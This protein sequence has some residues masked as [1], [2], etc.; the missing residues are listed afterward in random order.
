MQKQLIGLF[1]GFLIIMAG[2]APGV[3]AENSPC[4]EKDAVC[5][6][7]ARL[8]EAEQF[9]KI[10]EKID[11]KKTYSDASRN[12]IGQAY[13]MIAGRETSTPE[14][15][16]QFCRKALEYGS[17]SAY[18]GLY[19]IYAAKDPEAALGFLKQYIA[20]KPRDS[21][22]Y[23]IMGEAELE[24]KNYKAADA[25]LREAK[26]VARGHS[27][28]LE[29][30]S[31]QAGYLTGDYVYAG[32]MLDSAL[33]KPEYGKELRALASDPRFS[34]M[35]KRPEFKQYESLFKSAVR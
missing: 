18:M 32:T 12:I 16:E 33:K 13:L 9:D 19:F 5:R 22:P 11:P 23:V 31:F 8:A 27:A 15:E 28:N 14:Q 3:A 6:E 17:T 26:K 1:A 34:G 30:L 7:F 20:T 35:E 21:V 10:V 4:D 29:W 24:K 2:H 25:Y